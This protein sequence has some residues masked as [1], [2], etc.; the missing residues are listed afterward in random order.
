MFTHIL[1]KC[2]SQFRHRLK[3]QL[4]RHMH[5]HTSFFSHLHPHVPPTPHPQHTHI[6]CMYAHMQPRG[7][8]PHQQDSNSTHPYFVG[9]SRRDTPLLLAHG[10]RGVARTLPIARG[11]SVASARWRC[12]SSRRSVLPTRWRPVL[13]RCPILAALRRSPV[14]RRSRC[15]VLAARGSSV[16]GW[17]GACWVTSRCRSRAVASWRLP[18]AAWSRG[19][20]GVAAW[21]SL[22]R[23]SWWTSKSRLVQKDKAI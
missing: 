21:L 14:V 3:M 22:C 15:R 8:H 7:T 16:L 6:T 5:T 20:L 19:L 4:L 13:P 10:R 9:S 18:I 12:S 23:V 1:Q 11:R 17:S 2:A